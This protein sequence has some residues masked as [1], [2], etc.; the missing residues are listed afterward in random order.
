VFYVTAGFLYCPRARL[1]EEFNQS[2]DESAL[3]EQRAGHPFDQGDCLIGERYLKVSFAVR[4]VGRD[5]ADMSAASG[6]AMRQ[7]GHAFARKD[8][9]FE[10]FGDWRVVR[11]L[12]LN[13]GAYAGRV[14]PKSTGPLR[15]SL[16]A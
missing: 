6:D 13:L 11:E 15:R 5:A 8:R 12:E 4:G 10:L 9:I 16:L 7:S 2:D 3:C 1:F 14:F